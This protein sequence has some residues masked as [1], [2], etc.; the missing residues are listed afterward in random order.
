[1]F[2]GL[3]MNLG[4]KNN[5]KAT[6]QFTIHAKNGIAGGGAGNDNGDGMRW[7]RWWCRLTILVLK[8]CK[9]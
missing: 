5:N 9:N 3:E 8:S 7:R 1:V 4:G 2:Y 6:H